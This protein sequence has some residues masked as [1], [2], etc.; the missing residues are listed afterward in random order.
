MLNEKKPEPG[1]SEP[2]IKEVLL[3]APVSKV[4]KAITDKE[5]MKQCILIL[6][7]SNLKLVLSFSFQGKGTKAKTIYTYV[8]LQK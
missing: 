6:Q 1:K 5:K 4:W 3:N 7:S 8:K 2:I